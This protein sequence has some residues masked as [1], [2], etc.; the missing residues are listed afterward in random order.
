MRRAFWA[1]ALAWAAAGCVLPPD[2]LGLLDPSDDRDGGAGGAGGEGG[3]AAV[4]AR[5]RIEGGLVLGAQ[6]TESPRFRVVGRA[7]L[8]EVRSFGEQFEVQGRLALSCPKEAS[9]LESR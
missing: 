2:R 6:S 8:G 1:L 4:P 9:C 5:F 7:G 3:D